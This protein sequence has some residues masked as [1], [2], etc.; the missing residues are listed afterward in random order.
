VDGARG[1]IR[2]ILER[3]G[4]SRQLHLDT[5]SAE[6]GGE[7]GRGEQMTAGAAGSEEDASASAHS[8][9]TSS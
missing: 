1:K 8:A 7:S 2:V 4:V 3:P 6:R 9:G 5:A